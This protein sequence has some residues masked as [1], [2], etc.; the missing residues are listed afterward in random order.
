MHTT[1][2]A[3]YKT[4]QFIDGSYQAQYQFKIIYRVPAK[5]ADERMSADEVLDA[6]GAWAEANVDSLTIADGIRV[7]KVK[8]DTAAALF[9]RYEGDV[10]DHQILLTLIY[11][12]I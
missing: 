4:K 10:E 8:R 6:Y 1:I 12:V 3:A 7:R 11:E 5:N 2:Q 9:A